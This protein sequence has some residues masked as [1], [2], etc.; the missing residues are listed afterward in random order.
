MRSVSK[1]GPLRR[2]YDE[3]RERWPAIE[4]DFD[5]FAALVQSR[6]P[7][8]DP[9]GLQPELVLALAC[10]DGC[11]QAA[12]IIA[13]SY[14]GVI[15]SVASRGALPSMSPD[16]LRQIVLRDVLVGDG[17]R[18]PKICRYSGTGSLEGWMRSVATRKSLDLRRS[19]AAREVASED[20]IFDKLVDNA[21]PQVQY[22]RHHYGEQLEASFET[23]IA[24]MDA[25]TVNILR[26]LLVE[27]LSIDEV[28]ALYGIHRSTAAR[29]MSR[30]RDSLLEATREALL[31]RFDAGEDA[32]Q[33]IVRMLGSQLHVSFRRVLGGAEDG[34]DPGEPG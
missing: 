14:Q 28:A 27:K 30:A 20:S 22:L 7:G 17:D 29:R 26:H 31:E 13:A 8:D 11:K 1:Q 16:D 5:R 6:S 33:S 12:Q 32:L 10:C 34:E 15:E 19:A 3:G 9:S 2:L 18:P 24:R 23:A 25:R 21:D 4:L